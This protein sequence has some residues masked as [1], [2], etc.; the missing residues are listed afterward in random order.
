MQILIPSALH[1]IY[2]QIEWDKYISLEWQQRGRDWGPAGAG[3]LTI[4]ILLFSL[5]HLLIYREAD[6][7]LNNTGRI[8][9]IHMGDVDIQTNIDDLRPDKPDEASEEPPEPELP[10]IEEVEIDDSI[11]AG[12]DGTIALGI[13]TGFGSDGEYLPIVKV[14]PIYPRRAQTRGLEGYCVVSYTVTVTGATRDPKVLDC[15]SRVFSSASLRASLRFKYKPRIIDGEP[16][17]V[18]GVLNKFTY[19]LEQ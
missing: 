11:D 13:G 6:L 5:M 10:E 12:F 19:E 9:D 18:S 8:A 16:V 15:S 17:E 3:A 2:H 4:T 7:D 14:A 1:S